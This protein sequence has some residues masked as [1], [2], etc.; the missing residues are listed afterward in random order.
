[1]Y[2]YIHIYISVSSEEINDGQMSRAEGNEIWN[3]AWLLI[4][5]DREGELDGI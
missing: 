5:I 3:N 2:I 4:M 1:M